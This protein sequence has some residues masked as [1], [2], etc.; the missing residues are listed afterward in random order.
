[1]VGRVGQNSKVDVVGVVPCDE[2]VFENLLLNNSADLEKVP[3]ELNF[4]SEV[5]SL[6][7]VI[8]EGMPSKYPVKKGADTTRRRRNGSG[9]SA[10][11]WCKALTRMPWSLWLVRRARLCYMPSRISRSIGRSI[12]MSTWTPNIGVGS[13]RTS[14]H[15]QS[16]AIARVRLLPQTKIRIAMSV[17]PLRR[18]I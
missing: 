5:L 8:K 14:C 7:E 11:C 1:M 4:F 10:S 17:S 15:R 6:G 13:R 2:E 18:R 9:V 16:G 12:G 3:D